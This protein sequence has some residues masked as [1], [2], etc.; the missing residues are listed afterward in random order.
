M[1][2]LEKLPQ[3][4]HTLAQEERENGLVPLRVKSLIQ[5]QQEFYNTL[6]NT[7]KPLPMLMLLG[8]STKVNSHLI[9]TTLINF[10]NHGE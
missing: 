9:M 3:S 1:Q 6:K 7:I 2:E 10:A 4:W 5:E 8:M